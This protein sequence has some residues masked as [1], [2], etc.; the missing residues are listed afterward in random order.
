M[1]LYRLY[2]G[3]RKREEL[4][5]RRCYSTKNF[6]RFV[7]RTFPGSILRNNIQ[8]QTYFWNIFKI[9]FRCNKIID[10]RRSLFCGLNY[11]LGKSE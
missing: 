8:I 5:I 10:Q 6:W 7:E 9:M 3:A 11:F 4:G 1:S 2:L